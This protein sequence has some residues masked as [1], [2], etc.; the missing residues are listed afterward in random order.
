MAPIAGNRAAF[1]ALKAGSVAGVV[2]AG[3][4]LWRKNRVGA[5]VFMA[6]MD[7]AM[8]AVV[9]HNYATVRR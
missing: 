3:E 2:W 8:A 1:L 7:S 4:K 5:I 6:A 9:A